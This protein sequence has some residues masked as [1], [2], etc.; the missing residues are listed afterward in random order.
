MFSKKVKW[1]ETMTYKSIRAL[2][3]GIDVLQYLNTVKG[4]APPEIA[5][6]VNLPRPTV[7]RILETLS[8]LNLVYRSQLGDEYRLSSGVQRLAGNRSSVRL[9]WIDEIALP[10]L[11]ELTSEIIWPSDIAVYHKAAMVIQGTT[12]RT[13]PMSCDVGMVGN[14]RSMLMSPL[15]RAYLSH[16]P[17]DELK[18]ILCA[19]NA[20]S[21]SED[22]GARDRSF[23]NEIIETGCRD[24]VSACNDLPHPRCASLAAPIRLNGKVIACMNVVWR[25]NMLT[26]EDAM[27]Q[28]RD[29]L[30][31]TRDRIE[32][33]LRE[34]FVR[35]AL[36]STSLPET[37]TLRTGT[38]DRLPHSLAL[39]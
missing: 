32:A 36:G 26:I 15:G 9:N 34:H 12:H 25:A 6:N 3:R 35:P 13:S 18:S 29:P 37:Y 20:S 39:A 21:A 7:H 5:E 27:G 28:I 19:L 30:L 23:I 14:R 22:Q 10:A 1:E 24:G 2:E 4:A 8:E 11:L 33:Q 17:D 38:R 16:C 31:A